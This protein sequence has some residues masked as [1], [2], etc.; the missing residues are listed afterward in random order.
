MTHLVHSTGAPC[1]EMAQKQQ[2]SY[3]KNEC[4]PSK[5]DVQH[6]VGSGPCVTREI[7]VKVV[8]GEDDADHDQ[9]AAEK[10]RKGSG[11]ERNNKHIV[12]EERTKTMW[13]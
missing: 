11:N 1:I 2:K 9:E 8:L 7:L 4:R 3:A 12:H 6:M 5:G 13:A 10:E